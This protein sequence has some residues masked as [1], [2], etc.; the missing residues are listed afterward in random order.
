MIISEKAHY[1]ILNAFLLIVAISLIFRKPSTIIIISFFIYSFLNIKK[2]QFDN[3]LIFS[4]LAL[5]S[6]FLIHVLF[7]WN[8][9]SVVI[10]LK[11]VEKYASLLLFPVF[12]LGNYKYINV[13]FLL[14]KYSIFFSI[15]LSVLFLRY[16]YYFPELYQKYQNG[17][18]QWEMGYSFA[19]SFETHAPAL[20]MHIAFAASV[21]FYFLIQNFIQKKSLIIIGINFISFCLLY[22]FIL[23]VNTRLALLNLLLAL[24]LIICSLFLKSAVSQRA[25]VTGTSIFIISLFSIVFFIVKYPYMIEK[26]SVVTFDNLNKIGKLDEIDNVQAIGCNALV[27]R[28]S[29]WKS[30]VELIVKKPILGYGS[31]DSKKTLTE[32]YK[33]TNQQFLFRN[34]FPVHNQLLDFFLK[35]GFVGLLVFFIYLLNI[36]QTGVSLN[37][38]LIKVFFIMFFISNLVDDF[39]LRF[40]GIVYS[41][42]WISCFLC[43]RKQKLK[44]IEI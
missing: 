27:T 11:D 36:F 8:N 31:A 13:N 2:L 14:E 34:K 43:L 9:S 20:N 33:T 17:I 23:Y 44:Q 22:Y 35:F 26:Y 42:F 6:P 19:N 4:Q 30:T 41:G 37:N 1:K 18:H 15:V 16:V 39:L 3:K 7:L 5:V 40:D 25:A 28:I 12:I 38:T 21:A 29:I 10:G 24:F 32:Y